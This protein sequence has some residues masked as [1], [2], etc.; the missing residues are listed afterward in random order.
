MSRQVQGLRY[1]WPRPEV[2]SPG[3]PSIMSKRFSGWLSLDPGTLQAVSTLFARDSDDDDE[4]EEE[5][6]RDDD[7]DGDD[8]D[9]DEGY[10][11]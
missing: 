7:D 5:E 2:S 4:D 11:E 9:Q 8:E 3:V 6:D 1:S 10:S